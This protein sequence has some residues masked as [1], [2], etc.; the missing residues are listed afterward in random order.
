[1]VSMDTSRRDATNG[2]LRKIRALVAAALLGG[3]VGL[4]VLLI[5]TTGRNQDQMPRVTPE[6]FAGAK[7]R[8][9]SAGQHSYDLTV[10]VTGRQAATYQVAVRGGQ[11]QRATRDGLPLRQRRTQGTWSVPGMFTTIQSDVD[12]LEKHLHGTAD[13]STPQVLLRGVF[14]AELGYPLRYHRTELRKWGNNLE[15]AWEVVSFELW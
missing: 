6:D 1:M 8:W 9:R 13:R 2:K 14:H 15:A 7:Q 3:G 10:V 4:I 12:N 11:V 5:V